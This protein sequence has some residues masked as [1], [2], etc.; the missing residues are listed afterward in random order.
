MSTSST[1]LHNIFFNHGAR[2]YNLRV[3]LLLTIALIPITLVSLRPLSLGDTVDLFYDHSATVITIASSVLILAH[4]ILRLFTHKLNAV[5]DWFIGLTEI[6]I[7][8]KVVTYLTGLSFYIWQFVSPKFNAGFNIIL[9]LRPAQLVSLVLSEIWC[10]ATIMQCS[11]R[12]FAQHFVFFGGCSG[13]QAHTPL[14]VLTNRSISTPLIRG[15]SRG[16]MITRALI[17]SAVPILLPALA[18]YVIVLSPLTSK[19][20]ASTIQP[21]L[22]MVFDSSFGTDMGPIPVIILWSTYTP[23]LGLSVTSS[24]CPSDS[25]QKS[26]FTGS[27][28]IKSL[29]IP[30]G[31]VPSVWTCGF[32]EWFNISD[33]EIEL[34]VP[35]KTSSIYIQ[36]GQGDINNIAHYT[37]AVVLLPGSHLFGALSWTQQAVAPGF[38]AYLGSLTH[39]KTI[40]AG[41][42][43]SLQPDT[44]YNASSASDPG[45]RTL[46]V[47]QIQPNPVRFIQ[48]ST[49]NDAIAGI[50]TM[51]GFWAFLNGAFVLFFGAN[52]MYF[53]FGSR[54]L[55]ALGIVHIFQ[56]RRLV[57]NWHDDFPALR[58]EGGKPGSEGAG[59]VAFLRERLVVAGDEEMSYPVRGAEAQTSSL[60][61]GLRQTS[62]HKGDAI[63]RAGI[64]ET[65]QDDVSDVESMWKSGYRLDDVPLMDES[66]EFGSHKLEH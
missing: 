62:S 14:R 10:T 3:L 60:A 15:E 65:S 18:L 31:Y 21:S 27:Q 46:S 25:F 51:G 45:S 41:E 54:P 38:A 34:S 16:I 35:D 49:E 12:I 5:A 42:I 47:T 22:P 36:I 33:F 56:R 30:Q 11:T 61:Y 53:L 66:P 8:W 39:F 40:L 59:I 55:S 23:S 52:I 50:G 37:D 13:P 17:L 58:T 63:T 2:M 43:R 7:S 57:Q 32:A 9:V 48:Q 4:H 19:V 28:S 26:N 6:C 29:A 64:A 24:A 20:L 1:L 44:L